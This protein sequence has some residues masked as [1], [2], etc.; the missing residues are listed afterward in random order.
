MSGYLD[1]LEQQLIEAT[2]AGA[3][4]RRRDGVRRHRIPASGAGALVALLLASAVALAVTG[5]FSTGSAVRPPEHPMAGA[6]AGVA[7]RGT[8]LLPIRVVDPAGGLPW[9]MRL[10]RTSRRLVCLQVGRVEGAQLGV[11]GQDGAFGDDGRLHPVSPD[12]VGYHRD[13]TELSS[14]L[15]PGQTT[16]LEARLPESGVFGSPHSEAIPAAAR[17]WISYGLLG[18]AA[19]SVSYSSAGQTH[20][21]PVEPDSGAYLVVLPN[22][23]RSGFEIGGGATSANGFVTPQGAISSITYR[24]NG[25][26]CDESTPASEA[27][28]AHPQCPRPLI[29][30]RPGAPRHLNRPLRVHMSAGGTAIITFS[31]PYTVSSALSDY[32]VEIPSPCH[33]G[34][35]GIPVE[36]DLKAGETVHVTVRDV[37]ANACG[38]TVPVRVVYE[39]DRNRF[40]L[41]QPEIIVGQTSIRR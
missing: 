8:R 9:G 39:K 3:S 10:V 21:I 33:Q 35:N 13:T 11:L 14:C 7:A 16:S 29:A 38:P 41:G 15:Q 17:R 28:A 24:V 6:G 20:M 31:A 4:S 36:R 12:V 2:N 32:T 19:V 22:P 5:T 1:R 34:T 25:R 37:F 26:T 27:A 23:P 18:P 40:Q 30:P